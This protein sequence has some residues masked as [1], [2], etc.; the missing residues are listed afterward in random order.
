M[1]FDAAATLRCWAVDVDVGGHTY[2]IPARPASEWLLAVSD[3]AYL[4]IVPG[5]LDDPT[6][7]DDQL[8]DDDSLGAE[9]QAAA[10]AAIGAAAGCPWWTAVRLA[11]AI[12]ETWI[13]GELAIR[14][15]DPD[16]LSFAGYL[17]AAY[18]LTVRHL[19]EAKTAQ[20]DAQLEQPPMGVAPEEWF[21]EDAA[22][23]GFL[24]AAAAMNAS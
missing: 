1:K 7:L 13:G 8:I 9:C 16:R 23:A 22:S 10:R 2:T 15:V 5:L 24:A 17:A 6:V 19:D 20:L 12:G 11:R 21:D 14:A 4:E 3:G 18:R